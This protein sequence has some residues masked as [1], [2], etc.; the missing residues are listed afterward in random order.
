MRVGERPYH[1]HFT[2]SA[3][4]GGTGQ[5]PTLALSTLLG[6]SLSLTPLATSLAACHENGYQRTVFYGAANNT[7]KAWGACYPYEHRGIFFF[8]FFAF[9]K[10]FLLCLSVCESSAW[11]AQKGASDAPGAGVT[12]C[13]SQVAQ[14]CE[15]NPGPLVSKCSSPLSSLPTNLFYYYHFLKASHPHSPSKP[16]PYLQTR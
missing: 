16:F 8:F 7:A 1:P 11:E 5:H 9:L 12:G 2:E 3:R 15:W 4:C 6:G 13:H 14:C 10:L